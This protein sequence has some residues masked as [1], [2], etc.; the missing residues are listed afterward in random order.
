M[1]S[2]GHGFSRAGKRRAMKMFFLA[3]AG[4]SRAHCAAA[5]LLV[6]L[7]LRLRFG[8]RQY[9]SESFVIRSGMAKAMP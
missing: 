9:G 1:E 2:S 7:R 5:A 3:A 8:L 6:S 4:W